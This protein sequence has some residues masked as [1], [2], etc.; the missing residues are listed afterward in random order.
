MPHIAGEDSGGTEKENIE[1]GAWFH[2]GSFF[3]AHTMGV[4]VDPRV[5]PFLI[6]L[7]ALT[8][9]PGDH[10]YRT[11]FNNGPYTTGARRTKVCG[12]CAKGT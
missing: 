6:S 8:A 5:G 1:L 11:G 9:F 7:F 3:F 2:P 4:D 12:L 10:R